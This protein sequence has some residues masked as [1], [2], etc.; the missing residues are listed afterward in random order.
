[1]LF[2]EKSFRVAMLI[3][4]VSYSLWYRF[5]N[6]VLLHCNILNYIKKAE[7][8]SI[9]ATIILVSLIEGGSR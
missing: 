8:Y 1:M 4:M 7:L 6:Y 9:S 3:I 2:V 5:C